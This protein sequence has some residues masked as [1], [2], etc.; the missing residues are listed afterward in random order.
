MAELKPEEIV[1]LPISEVL[2]KLE[3]SKSGLTISDVEER[4]KKYGYNEIVKKKKTAIGD[5]FSHFANPLVMIL[6]I[7]S[8][9]SII[10]KEL[11]NSV[12][13]F[14]IILFS[15]ILD[16][17]QEF[18]AEKTAEKLEER[19]R[20]TTL[21]LR[22][23]LKTEIKISEIVPGDI[24]Y[25]SAGDIIPADCRIIESKDLAVDQSALTGE[26]FPVDKSAEITKSEEWKNYL[27]MG[28]FVTTGEAAVVVVKT[29]KQTEYGE[30]I[31][32][33]SL[34]PETE[35]EG[36][37]KRFSY[38]ITQ[39]TFFLV[40]FT[41][42]VNTL[43]KRD[44]IDSVLFAITLA[45]GLT[46][47]LLPMITSIN[48][49][50]GALNMKNKDVIVKRLAAIQN[51]G[52]MDVLCTDKTGT[53][54][55]NRV[56]LVRHVNT[57][58]DEDN[59]VLFYSYINS[60]FQTGL[61]SALDEAIIEHKQINID[62]YKK[63]DEIPFDFK[64]KR[65]S[66]VAEDGRRFIAT[67]GAPEEVISI[68][69]EYENNEKIKPFNKEAKDKVDKI[70]QYLS[71]KGFRVLGVSYKEIS[72]EKSYSVNDE[73]DMVFVGFVAFMDPPKESAKNSI[74]QLQNSGV[75]LKI[76]TGDNELVT[77]MICTELGFKIKDM[78]SG[79]EIKT[80]SDEAL[81]NAAEN[82]NIF[83]RVSPIEKTRI[84]SALK[85]NNHVVGFMGD[86]INDA[87]SMKA[88]DVGI[89]VNN[90]VD[91]AK[92]TA[93]IIL[94]KQDLAVLYDGVL[95][96][97]KT[98]G[99]TMKYI[100]MGLSSNFGNMFSAAVASLF[101]PFLPML[102]IQILLN[103]LMYDVSQI[104]IPSDNVDKEYIT[105]PKKLDS[106]FIRDFMFYIGPISSI[107]DFLTF[108]VMLY[109]FKAPAA[110]FQTA[111]FIESFCTQTIIIFS[112]RTSKVPFFK[113]KPSRSLI[114]NNLIMVSMAILIP[115]TFIGSLFGFVTPPLSFMGILVIFVITYIILVE[116]MK[117]WFYKKYSISESA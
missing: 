53:L 79:N 17:Y 37:L 80:M 85:S 16:S 99:N 88:S 25:L 61:K 47:E 65:V 26:A 12:V 84:I 95:E 28:T 59:K 7:V 6:V 33:V 94:L 35:F 46:P 73:K 90:A 77:R 31:K 76:L 27:F 44:F 1:H 91:I 64:R 81:K 100:M 113:S 107:Y 67:K 43:L 96:G 10:L 9:I 21:A 115:F 55:E 70:Y 30:I 48:L 14:I 51:F 3:T 78:L 114:L 116:L 117:K 87:P 19:I 112:I 83:T 29:G 50:K 97:R 63:I 4:V 34:R 74:K 42:I 98:F 93:D 45:V 102:P 92:E 56:T 60:H 89:S 109:F 101:L 15:V 103:N 105:K 18:R 82:A 71:L 104:A 58:G 20:T 62:D 72:K 49:S 11:F 41:V 40:L 39:V 23:G 13:I 8:V 52:S 54:T 22:N 110:L 108:F 86:G 24:V 38:L 36:G 57:N 106:K 69:K 2:K 66:V 68:C 75:E 32:S 111:W 5:L